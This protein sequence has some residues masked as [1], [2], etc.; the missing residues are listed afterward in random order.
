VGD[1]SNLWKGCGL[2]SVQRSTVATLDNYFFFFAILL[3][4]QDLLREHMAAFHARILPL[5]F[6]VS[7]ILRMLQQGCLIE[8]HPSQILHSLL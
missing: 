8:S 4:F 6:S 3:S 1:I 2:V 5:D 7:P